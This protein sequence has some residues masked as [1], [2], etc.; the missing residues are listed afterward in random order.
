MLD[1]VEFQ[2]SGECLRDKILRASLGYIV[3]Y[4]TF[5]PDGFH[6][7]LKVIVDHLYVAMFST[8]ISRL[9]AAR[10][11]L[12]RRPVLAPRLLNIRL[13][14]Y[15]QATRNA[16]SQ[17]GKPIVLEKPD[18]FRPPSHPAR[19][20]RKKIRNYGPALTQEQEAQQKTK[21]YPHM[22]PPEGSFFHSFLTDKWL[23]VW[24]A[25]VSLGPYFFPPKMAGNHKY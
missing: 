2:R 15:Q 6:R 25:M 16:S 19:L 3:L 1:V 24:I 9:L 21:Q 8:S 23:H 10:Q 7:V 4:Q 20:P 5:S 11:V 13:A 22:M 12:L 17:P 18:Q 14:Q